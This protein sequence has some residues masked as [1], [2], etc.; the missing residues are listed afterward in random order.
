MKNDNILITAIHGGGIEPGS[1]EIARRIANIGSMIF[2]V[3]K[4]YYLQIINVY[5][6]LQPIMMNLN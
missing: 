3:F 4:D 6:L 5:I 1:T 2:I